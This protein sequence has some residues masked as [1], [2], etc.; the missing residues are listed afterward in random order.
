M[1]KV[2]HKNGKQVLLFQSLKEK[3]IWWIVEHT[4]E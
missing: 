3:E 4:E 1:G 2:C